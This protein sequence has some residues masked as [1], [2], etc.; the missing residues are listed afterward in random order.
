MVR[1][2]TEKSHTYYIGCIAWIA[3]AIWLMA[4]DF[5]VIAFT[6][7]I[8][9]CIWTFGLRDKFESE[10]APSAYSVYNRG[11]RAVVGSF[12]GKQL[13]RQL[14]GG[15][16]VDSDDDEPTGEGGPLASTRRA[17]TKE[18][19]SENDRLRRRSDAAAAAE[20]RM[21]QSQE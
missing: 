7:T 18:H 17:P 6:A 19:T 14:R 10:D 3:C 5:G 8:L 16:A 2:A 13:D 15:M 20:R 12:T 1:A 9:L 11:G 4:K 21:R